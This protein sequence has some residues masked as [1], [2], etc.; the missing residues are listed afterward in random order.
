MHATD[1][2][3]IADALDFAHTGPGTLAGRYLRRYWQ[4]VHVA[5]AL[6]RG[7]AAP[8]RIMSEDFTLYRGESGT[9]HVVAARCAHRGTQ[10][11]VGWVEEDC[12]RC[13][14]HGWKYDA[15]GQ[16]VEQPGEGDGFADRVR[17]ASYPTRE[18]LGLI[19][20]YLGEGEPPPFPPYPAFEGEGQVEAWAE[21]FTCNFFQS[22]ENTADEFH[23][24]Y[25]HSGG[26]THQRL[27]E[28]P[29][30]SAAETAYGLA[31]HSRRSDG[32][33][34]ITLHL[35]PNTTRVIVPPFKG[36][37]GLGGWRDSY[38]TLVPV[39]DESHLMFGICSTPGFRATRQPP[40]RRCAR[41][42]ASS[43]PRRLHRTSWRSTCWRDKPAS[44]ILRTTCSRW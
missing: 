33:V 44:G 14:Y 28:V 25:V 43:S 1:G 30:M 23:V 12:I 35:M 34:R 40:T 13:L 26:G 29:E 16:C 27:A 18:H 42:T 39:D 5:D 10:L 17:V 4:P 22:Y 7:E 32:K 3:E 36:F 20:A 37:R 2:Q 15:T 19:F 24:A 38:F 6:P 31:R 8:I 21:R 41:S 9:P 11:S